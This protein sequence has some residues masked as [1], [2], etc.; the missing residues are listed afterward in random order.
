M[1]VVLFEDEHVSRLD[2]VALAKPAFAIHSV[3]HSLVELLEL[4]GRHMEFMVRPHLRAIVA[5]DFAAGSRRA[6]ASGG[7][8]LWV[9]ARLAPSVRAFETLR[10]LVDAGK[11]GIVATGR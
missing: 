6:P 5:R 11:P 1:T 10:K 4:F 7:P 2:P 3:G 8:T 9:N